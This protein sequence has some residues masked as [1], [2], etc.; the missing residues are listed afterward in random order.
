MIFFL[1]YR[2][3]YEIF[4]NLPERER[5]CMDEYGRRPNRSSAGP[6]KWQE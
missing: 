1:K 2:K 5:R 3:I 6:G 4:G